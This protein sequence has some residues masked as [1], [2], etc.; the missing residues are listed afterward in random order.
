MRKILFIGLILMSSVAWAG[1][2]RNGPYLGGHIGF[3]AGSYK[4]DGEKKNDTRMVW[5]L[6]LGARSRSIRAEFELANTSRAHIEEAY[7]EQQRYMAQFYYDIPLRPSAIRPF[8]NAGLGAAHTELSVPMGNG[9]REKS[10]K[11]TFCWNAGAGLG[12]NVNKWL[13]FD[14]G[15]RYIDAGSPKFFDADEG[16]KIRHHEGYTGVRVTF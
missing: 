16:T 11:S 2:Y 15:Y 10:D 4:T 14:L 12:I 7:V 6:V 8:L 5:D 13:S 3:D 1:E 9:K